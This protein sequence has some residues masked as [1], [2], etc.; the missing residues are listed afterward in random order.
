MTPNVL[1]PMERMSSA[2][3]V[4]DLPQISAE[5]ATGAFAPTLA[6]SREAGELL[7]QLGADPL[8]SQATQTL[9][10]LGRQVEV[11]TR[12]RRWE[13]VAAIMANPG[14]PAQ[15]D[16]QIV[17]DGVNQVFL[18]RCA[19]ERS[20]DFSNTVGR[21]PNDP[22]TG[23]PFPNAALPLALGIPVV[24]GNV[25]FYNETL[26]RAILPTPVIGM[27][28]LLDEEKRELLV[29]V[30]VHFVKARGGTGAKVFKLERLTLAPRE[31]V[32]LMRLMALAYRSA[33]EGR[34]LPA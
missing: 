27:V 17:R 32:E 16:I 7:A 23:Q 13:L 21:R 2:H 10:T 5:A 3:A 19:A 6:R 29:D 11:E 25:S 4:S 14:R 33:E 28:G 9:A 31:Q 8:G 20:G 1:E 22:L 30:A 12:N 24:G 34:E 26:G 18:A 15:R